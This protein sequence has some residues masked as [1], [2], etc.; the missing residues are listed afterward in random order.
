MVYYV[1]NNHMYWV[2]DKDEARTRAACNKDMDTKVRPDMFQNYE[3][4]KNEFVDDEKVIKPIFEDIDVADLTKAEYA[5]SVILY[6]NE[7]H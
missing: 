5:N 3:K 1:V 7:T 6:R 2:G 4:C